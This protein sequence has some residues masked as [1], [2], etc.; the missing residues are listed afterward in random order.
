MLTNRLNPNTTRTIDTQ[1][2]L[3]SA[4]GPG[5]SKLRIVSSDGVYGVEVRN[6]YTKET[7]YFQEVLCPADVGIQAPLGEYQVRLISESKLYKTE[8]K[9]FTLT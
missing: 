8:Y 1:P 2:T 4:T 9:D 7:V 6:K 3:T 5:G